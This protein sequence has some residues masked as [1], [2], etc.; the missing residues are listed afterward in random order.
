MYSFY[1]KLNYD[2]GK[3]CPF[4]KYK[5]TYIKISETDKPRKSK[6]GFTKTNYEIG[7]MLCGANINKD[8]E[9][10]DE[11]NIEIIRTMWNDRR[12]YNKRW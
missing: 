9:Y 5:Y 8:F 4:C 2:T 12:I 3:S 6:D 1:D 10:T 11:I 7:C